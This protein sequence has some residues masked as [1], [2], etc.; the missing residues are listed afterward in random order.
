[1]T[2]P[3]KPIDGRRSAVSGQRSGVAVGWVCAGAGGGKPPGW[4]GGQLVDG[5]GLQESGGC[6]G[7]AGQDDPVVDQFQLLERE[8][9]GDAGGW[10][11]R[12]R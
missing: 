5:D 8:L 10:R 3:V 2:G 7:F 12:I 1:M 6:G 9:P 11:I 4:A